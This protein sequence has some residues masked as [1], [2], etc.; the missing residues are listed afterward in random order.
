MPNV[1]LASQN[2]ENIENE[3]LVVLKDAAM[4][5]DIATYRSLSLTIARN[6]QRSRSGNRPLRHTT[7]AYGHKQLSG[8][9]KSKENLHKSR[10][11]PRA[12]AYCQKVE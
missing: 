6:A 5:R 2:V 8:I 10:E 4:S 7:S 12:S 3:K 9:R 1:D 11:P